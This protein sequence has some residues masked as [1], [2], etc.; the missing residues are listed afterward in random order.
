MKIADIILD[1]IFMVMLLFGVAA[2][3]V[4]AFVLLSNKRVADA[5]LF[6][7][8]FAVLTILIYGVGKDLVCKLENKK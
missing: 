7:C 3:V 8:G 2:C 5:G 4:V 1:I 6:F